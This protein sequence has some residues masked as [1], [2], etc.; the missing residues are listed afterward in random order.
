MSRLESIVI[1]AVMRVLVRSPW[2]A[3]QAYLLSLFVRERLPDGRLVK[4]T[5]DASRPAVLALS[6]DQFRSD[7]ECL[8][9]EGTFRILE[10]A[11]P[12]MRRLVYRFY[13]AD[14][15]WPDIISHKIRPDLEPNRKRCRAFLERLLPA[16][17]RRLGIRAVISPHMHYGTDV[18]WGAV[19]ETL[20]VPYV[21]LH[22]ENLYAS[23]QVI[24]MVLR[25]FAYLGVQFEGRRLITHNPVVSDVLV[26]SGF[27]DA[28]R[29]QALGCIR[30][31][32]YIQRARGRNPPSPARRIAIFPYSIG[33]DDRELF[34]RLRLAFNRM[35]AFLVRFALEN[36]DIEIVIKPKA[37]WMQSWREDTE[38][39]LRASGLSLGDATNV[40][41]RADV[42]VHDLI[43]SSAVVLGLN[44]TTVIEAGI[45]GRYTVIPFLEELH[46][47]EVE[48]EIL[49]FSSFSK[50]IVARNLDELERHLRAGLAGT[51][52]P[53]AV[54]A[55]YDAVFE[56]Y[57]ST[58]DAGATARYVH[59]LQEVINDNAA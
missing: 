23:Q 2:P 40:V 56:R 31:D 44:T 57:V 25:R 9:A 13:P 47:L 3:V 42:D 6:A 20:G 10:L 29:A 50:L 22:R 15:P 4:P 37:K 30:M 53:P 27:V 35:Y 49:F 46:V 8:A 19:S 33:P 14:A 12:I 58:L 7:P 32:P 26:R 34:R 1:G 59:L 55:E 52:L 17:Y 36:P 45:A 51:S 41:V 39:G 24:E 21:V 16:F 5:A 18:D 48:P 28:S 43:L 54:R 38:R 11:T